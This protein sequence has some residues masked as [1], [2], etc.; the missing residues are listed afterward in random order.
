M[1]RRVF[2]PVADDVGHAVLRVAGRLA[3][4]H[5]QS[6]EMDDFRGLVALVH[7]RVFGTGMDPHLRPRFADFR[8]G[9]DMIPMRVRDEN[10]PEL[11]LFVT[12]QSRIGFA[13]R[14]V[15]NNAASRVTSSQ[16]R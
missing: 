14:P 5:A 9:F 4:R 16:T 6:A 10:V 3:M 11:K 1:I 2:L 7:G 13:S 15:S 8:Q 12:M